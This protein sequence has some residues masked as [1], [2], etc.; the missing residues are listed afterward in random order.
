MLKIA[1][2]GE[3]NPDFPPHPATSAAIL[4][5]SRHLGVE[6]TAD[7][8]STQDID[9]PML[10]RCSAI[11]VAPGSPYKNL[12]KTLQA[13]R[14]ARENAIPCFGTCGGFQH[15]VI[16]Y[17]RNVL[18]YKDAQHAEYDPYASNLFISSLACSLAGRQMTLKLAAGSKVAEIYSALEVTENYYCNF[19]VNPAV[20]SLLKNGP[21]QITGSDS[22]G[23]IR[24]LELPGHPFFVATLFLPQLLSH[25]SAPHPLVLAFLAAAS[26]FHNRGGGAA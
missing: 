8:V 5:S 25:P 7:W 26:S 17:A 14:Y 10:Q 3:Y 23:E 12:E 9:I 15:M 21:M 22:E 1:I 20:V 19:G 24:V 4:H 11:W 13:I 2:L 18:A 16:E 6:T